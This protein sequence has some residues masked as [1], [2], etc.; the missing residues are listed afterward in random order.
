MMNKY[1]VYSLSLML[2]GHISAFAQQPQAT[3]MAAA[4]VKSAVTASNVQL[5]TV[6]GLVINGATHKPVSGAL[7][8]TAEVDGYSAL[9][10]SDG[11]YEI[12][13]PDFASSLQ[14]TAP[15]MNTVRV[16]LAKGQ[17]QRQAVIYPNTFADN[18]AAGNNVLDA[19]S[20]SGFGFSNAVTIEEEIQKRLGAEVHTTLRN[21]TPGVGGVMFMNGLNS[22]N[23]N[24]QPLIVV[25]GVIFDQQYGRS[26]IHQGFYNDILSNISPTDIANVTVLRN[27]TS[28]YGA[29][30]A[31]GVI[32]IETRRNH[33]MATRITASL[34]AG[35]TLEP[36]YIDMMNANEFKDYAS[37]LLG[38]TTT[39]L[40]SFKFLNDDPTYYYYPQYHNNTDWKD[41]VY[42]TAV[43]QNYNI[44]VEGGD[45]VAS[46][47]LSLGYINNQ[48][49]L[50]YNGMNR[51]N[52]RFNTDIQL[53]KKFSIR[54]DASF[55]NQTRNL[56][57]DGAPENYTDG[58]PTSPAF[59]AY[60]KSPM[61]SPYAYANGVLSNSF[62][63]ITDE[64]YLDEALASYSNYNYKLAN[65]VAMNQYADAENK[66]HFENSMVNIAVT[67]KFQFNKHLA[68][69]EHFS[70]NLVNTNEKYY[71]PLN[72]VPSYYV[73]AVGDTRENEIRSLASKQNSVFSDTRIDWNNRYGAHSL[74]V[75]GGARIN[76][77]S[78]TLSSQWGYNTGNDKTPF[79]QSSLRNADSKGL[80][81]SWDS[82][83]W[84]AQAE[85]NY[86]QRY[87]VQANLTAE[88]SSRFGKHASN[89][90]RAFNAP[91]GIFPGI[92]AGWVISNE[93]WMASVKPINYLKVTAGF[94]VSGNDDINYYASRSYFTASKVL[95]AVSGLSFAN[96]GNTKLQW[97][98][99]RRFNAGLETNLL[100]DR[101]NL[102]FNW[103]TSKTSHLL[104]YQSL[105]F[106]TGL[107]KN[108][109]NNGALKNTGFD[110]TLSGKVI[111]TKDFQ[112]ELG[113]SLAHY[114]NEITSLG[115]GTSFINTSVYGAT[116]HSEVGKA[117]NLFYGYK[118]LGVFSTS[119][120][121]NAAGLYILGDN[122]VDRNYFKAGDM[123]FAD[124]N[125]D[126]QITDADRTVIGDPNPDIYGNIFTSVN[127][128][129]FRLDLNFNYSVGNDVYNYMRSQLEGGSRFMNQTTALTQ[130]WQ[131][132]GQ[133][134]S[135]PRVTFQDPMGNS[136]FSD[137]WIEDGSYLKLKT[138]TLSYSLPMHSA[139]LQG[140]QFWVQANNLLT[141]TKYLGSDP[142]FTMTSN[143]LGQGIDLGQLPQCR[144][145]VAGVKIN[146]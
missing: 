27:G 9:T 72:G 33:S 126:H 135:V 144:S 86:L 39:K 74:H 120:E 25:D 118:T 55:D 35:I 132:E 117:A 58:T 62:L 140:L 30:G 16:G 37:D 125:G 111:S 10:H 100:N 91:W 143:V 22:L 34:S 69:S 64:S 127:Y 88:T 42:R 78:Y 115:N 90:L 59:L 119:E 133:V 36:K 141:F 19:Q 105:G 96:I 32:L 129:R 11:T 84:Y 68:L 99:T 56:R 75:F 51:I 128:K 71:I 87:Y 24:A 26:M 93:P 103:Y 145:F 109:T 142:E 47:N 123:H 4:S 116:I 122:G 65:P 45:D 110:V 113:A 106:L 28:L 41:Y 48:S 60:V 7:V 12:K 20:T 136:R 67:P 139:F 8:S 40:T 102:R 79:M 77:E 73:A 92:Q 80:N 89:S 97:E 14:I 101:I 49:P 63:D 130:R 29:K 108:W 23:S 13:V 146:L 18:Y 66:N 52:L 131:T 54:F 70:Y 43:T 17:M 61:L 82:W 50:K 114:K 124:L 46:Y 107:D 76:W 57:N 15:D 53:T 2:L 121:A 83:A 98:S 112:W 31:N 137:R 94:D 95:E 104:A 5:R 1:I 6:K 44:N 138:V 21:G 81:D 38:T 85:Y 134:T 3:A